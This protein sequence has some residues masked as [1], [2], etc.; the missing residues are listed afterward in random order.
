M[1]DKDR[2]REMLISY[3]FLELQNY[4]TIPY[5]VFLIG[6]TFWQSFICRVFASFTDLIL[7]YYFFDTKI[8]WNPK[9]NNNKFKNHLLSGLKLVVQ[10]PPLYALKIVFVNL[11]IIPLFQKLGSNIEIIEWNNIGLTLIISIL[12]CFTVG[13][14]YSLF[15]K[16]ILKFYKKITDLFKTKRAP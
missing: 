1:K 6:F 16:Q 12:F 10:S 9:K 7:L 8:I 15:R 11:F 14:F 2:K 3:L 13:F 4:A 5:E